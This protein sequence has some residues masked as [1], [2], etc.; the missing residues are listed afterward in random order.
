MVVTRAE[1]TRWEPAITACWPLQADYV[2]IEKDGVHC[3]PEDAEDA[4]IIHDRQRISP[5]QGEV[6]TLV[7]RVVPD[8]IDNVDA[9]M[10][11]FSRREEVL[12]AT[13][14]G[15]QETD[16]RAKAAAQCRLIDGGD[17][18]TVPEEK[19]QGS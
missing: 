9:I 4:S 5:Y 7:R 14:C 8:E 18:Y 17:V 11:Q 6:E 13:L 10:I 3:V 12:I 19:R 16:I 15:V 2:L 1:D